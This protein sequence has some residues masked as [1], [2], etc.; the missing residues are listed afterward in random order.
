MKHITVLN[1]KDFC[2]HGVF[3]K[4]ILSQGENLTTSIYRK[5]GEIASYYF[6]ANTLK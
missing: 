4:F 2:T 6:Q 5:S 1:E 3:N